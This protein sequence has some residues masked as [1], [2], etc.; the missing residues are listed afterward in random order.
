MVLDK[1][2]G[3]L[4]SESLLPALPGQAPALSPGHQEN[5]CFLSVGTLRMSSAESMLWQSERG[6]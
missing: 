2:V 4:R 5:G 3:D 1:A 6:L